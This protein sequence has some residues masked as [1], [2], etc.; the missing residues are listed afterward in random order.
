MNHEELVVV[1]VAEELTIR[2][3]SV[4]LVAVVVG[5]CCLLTDA[6]LSAASCP[7]FVGDDPP[8][9]SRMLSCCPLRCC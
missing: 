8:L 3:L 7:V 5:Y 4:V 2:K 1:V 6:D 9:S